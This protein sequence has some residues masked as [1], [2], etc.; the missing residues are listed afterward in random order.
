MQ[1]KTAKVVKT[2]K[3]NPED[4][5]DAMQY[6]RDLASTLKKP[7]TL[8]GKIDAMVRNLAQKQREKK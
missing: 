4:Y 7:V 6:C 1:T 3:V 2:Y 8:A 5:A